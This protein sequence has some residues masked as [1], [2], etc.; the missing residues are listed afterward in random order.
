VAKSGGDAGKT[1]SPTNGH[2]SDGR[3]LTSNFYSGFSALM[4]MVEWEG[5]SPTYRK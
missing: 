4:Q 3:T 5:V 1:W 2:D